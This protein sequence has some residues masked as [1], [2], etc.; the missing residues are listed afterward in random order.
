MARKFSLVAVLFAVMAAGLAQA[1]E[2]TAPK[3]KITVVLVSDTYKMQEQG[4]RGGYARI[5]GVIRAERARAAKD[6]TKLLAI[7]AGDVLSPCLMCS[8]D[9]GQHAV[10][11]MNRIGFD[12]FVPGNHE[13]D[14]GKAGYLKRMSEARFPILAANL[15]LAGGKPLAGHRD[16]MMIDVAGV[17]VGIIGLTAQDSHEKSNPGDLKI[18]RIRPVLQRKAKEL[19]AAGAQFLIGIIH[20]V[21][22]ID[23]RLHDL[24]IVDV[25]LS[26]DDHDIR[27]IYNGKNVFL[28]GG[29][30]GLYVQALDIVFDR[31]PKDGKRLKWSPRIRVIDTADVT[32]DPQIAARVGHYQALLGKELDV[33]LAKLA[34]P[35]DSRSGVVRSGEAAWGNLI[36][37][38]IRQVTGA[39][40]AIMNGGGIRGGKR[41]EAG[42]V[43]TRRNV[44]SELPFSNKTL[45]FRLTGAQIRSALE[46]GL[47]EYP[48]ASG[49]FLH[50]SG[51]KVVF[52]ASRK[53][54]ERVVELTIGGKP[55]DQRKY[56]SVTASDF[57]LRGGDGFTQF[58]NSG[59]R[60]RVEDAKLIANDVMVYVR[61]LGTIAIAPEGRVTAH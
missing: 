17:K 2:K 26:G 42:H 38:A 53:P 4:G 51:A 56:Y 18:Q 9:G 28:E 33:G 61:K 46:H 58:T 24:G 59:L 3:P 25:L 39:D 31:L 49:Q 57:F 50:V 27:Y 55:V 20:A 44:L 41:Y 21:R 13:Y 16:H 8:F 48:R 32:P 5:A 60:T 22:T 7:H 35:L 54:G 29:E 43:L 14:A 12:I 6:R 11:I 30:D 52:D 15:R 1:Q 23:T 19:R 36:A 37:D 10:D 34:K 45:L 47:A 40:M